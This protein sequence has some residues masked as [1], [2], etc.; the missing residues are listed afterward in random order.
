MLRNRLYLGEIS[1]KGEFYPAQHEPIVS[2]E[3]WDRVHAFVNKR[4]HGPRE[5]KEEYP[6]LLGGL[7]FAPDGQHMIHQYTKKK[8]GRMYRYYVPYLE[9]RRSASATQDGKTK[10]LGA[11]PAAEIEGA[12][13]NKIEL[14]LMEP[15]PLIG[16][17]RSCLRHS[18]GAD[19]QEE[20]V[21][22]SMRRI[23]E[24]WKQLFP[25]E[26]Q[27]ISQLLIERVNFRDGSLDIH[28]GEDGW[29]GLDPEIV[30]HAYVEVSKEYAQ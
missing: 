13:L 12:V 22:V 11:L 7:L 29:I 23:S 18:A 26:Q 17:W 20:L 4:K 2:S 5:R 10:S 24:V 16:V 19:L 30:A 3:L 27:R 8:N 1:H 25:A 14:S 9:R 6:V 15:E 21:V 28:W